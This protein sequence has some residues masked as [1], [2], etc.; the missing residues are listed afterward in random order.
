MTKNSRY[1][2]RATA[3][4]AFRFDGSAEQAAYALTGRWPE[5]GSAEG[6]VE[7]IRIPSLQGDIIARPGDWIVTGED[8]KREVWGHEAF[9][10]AFEL[11]P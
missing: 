1:Q 11:A 5:D 9:W 4:H 7:Y 6:T 3:V 10:A 2:P 8:G